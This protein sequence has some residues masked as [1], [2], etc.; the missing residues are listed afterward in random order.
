MTLLLINNSGGHNSI[1]GGRFVLNNWVSQKR[2]V[3]KYELI[4]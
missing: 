1:L 4:A 3:G 2:H